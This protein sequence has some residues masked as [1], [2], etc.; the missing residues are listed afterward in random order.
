L[1]RAAVPKAVE[2][3]GGHAGFVHLTSRNQARAYVH[4]LRTG[5]PERPGV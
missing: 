3:D 1:H 4:R 2:R 5:Q